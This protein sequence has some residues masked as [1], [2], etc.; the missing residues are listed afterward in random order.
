M[1]DPW[2][3]PISDYEFSSDLGRENRD[4]EET[5]SGRETNGTRGGGTVSRKEHNYRSGFVRYY[6]PSE[7]A[8][9]GQ[10]VRIAPRGRHTGD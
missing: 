1:I 2:A 4:Y 3:D 7:G 6:I 9:Q 10:K 8:K 5:V